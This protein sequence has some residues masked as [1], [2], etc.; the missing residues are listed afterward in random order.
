MWKL[1]GMCVHAHVYCH[2]IMNMHD[3]HMMCIYTVYVCVRLC[4][5]IL[6]VC[7]CVPHKVTACMHAHNVWMCTSL[8]NNFIL[9]SFFSCWIT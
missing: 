8:L 1:A 5:I 9:C 2:C 4:I 3:G 7:V 6:Y